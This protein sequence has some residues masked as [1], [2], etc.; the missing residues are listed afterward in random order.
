MCLG[1][2]MENEHQGIVYIRERLPY[3]LPC[4]VRAHKFHVKN[5]VSKIIVFLITELEALRGIT[6]ER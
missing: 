3:W 6:T 2:G 4:D 5:L 1:D